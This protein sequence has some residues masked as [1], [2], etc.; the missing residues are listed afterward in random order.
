[1]PTILITGSSSGFGLDTARLFLG[2]DWRVVATMRTPRRDLLP[3]SE[4]LQ[5]LPLD[6]TDGASI[7]S[8]VAAVGPIDA[9]VNNAGVGLL[10]VFEGTPLTA[11]RGTFDTNVF[12]AMAVTQAFLPQFR[13]RRAGVVVNV[14][15]STTMLALPML[16]AYTASKAALNAFTTSLAIELAP[17]GVRVRLVLPG[18]A[19]ATAFGRNAHTHMQAQGVR[20]PE[21]YIAFAQGVLDQMATRR[22]GVHTR[23]EDVAE[24]IWRAVTDP[25]A[26]LSQPAGADAL[27]VASA[28]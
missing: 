16:A 11:V 7:E 6:V 21:P 10:G 20:V 22:S 12:G 25:A 23:S 4:Q 19:P 26:P 17:F 24:A 8:L 9:L 2:R 5:V 13:E 15:S 27:A 18:S 14:S 3:A 1:M 28:G